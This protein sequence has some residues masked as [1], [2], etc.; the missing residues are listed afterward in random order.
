MYTANV[1]NTF[2]NPFDYSGVTPDYV[3]SAARRLNL[4]FPVDAR[5]TVQPASGDVVLAVVEEVNP[6]YPYLEI[7]DGT[8]VSLSAGHLIIGSIGSRKA[9]H[10]FSGKIPQELTIGQPLSL[11]NKGGVIGD[12]TAFHRDLEWPTQLRYLGTIHQGDQPLNIKSASLPF[13]EGPLPDVPLVVVLGTCMNSGKTT[14]CKTIVQNFAS[15]GV[16]VHGGK[17]AGVACQQDLVAL[18]KAGAQKV[19]SF[20]DFGFPSSADTESLVPVARSMVH[21]LADPKPDFIILEMGDGILGGYHVSSLFSDHEF[22]SKQ[23]CT[24]VCANDFMGTWGA[25]EW[26]G[27]N[28]FPAKEHPIMI[29]GPVTDSGE[30]IRFIESTWGVS[31]ANPFDCPGKLCSFVHKSLGKC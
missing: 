9:L 21:Y 11:L 20:H 4:E 7:A 5:E 28:G 26:M 22:L 10:G 13:V 27:K 3:S 14:V 12:C 18:Q 16:T 29:S 23:V 30:G 17:V 15:R 24:V 8:T 6:A 31:A 25:L 2:S 19:T 1:A